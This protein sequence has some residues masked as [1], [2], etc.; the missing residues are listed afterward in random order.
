VDMK[1]VTYRFIFGCCVFAG[2]L[3]A[4]SLTGERRAMATACSS[5]DQVCYCE[6]DS[7]CTAGTIYGCVGVPVREMQCGTASASCVQYVGCQGFTDVSATLCAL[8]APEY[9]CSNHPNIGGSLE[10]YTADCQDCTGCYDKLASFQPCGAGTICWYPNGTNNDAE[11]GTLAGLTSFE[12]VHNG[13][14]NVIS[15]STGTERLNL[16]FNVYKVKKTGGI[17]KRINAKLIPGSMKTPVG[18]VYRLKDPEGKPGDLYWL[19]NDGSVQ[20]RGPVEAKDG[21]VAPLV[22]RFD[23]VAIR[24]ASLEKRRLVKTPGVITSALTSGECSG[25]RIGVAENGLYRVS[26]A[27]L[28]AAG[29]EIEGLSAS[30]LSITN[31]GMPV[32]FSASSTGALAGSDW[33]EFYGQERDSPLSA[34]SVYMLTKDAD[35]HAGLNQSASQPISDG[36]YAP[37]YQSNVRYEQNKLYALTPAIDDY[38]YWAYIYYD[39]PEEEF[40]LKVKSPS[41][42][43]D[44]FTFIADLDGISDNADVEPDHHHQVFFNGHLVKDFKWDGVGLHSLKEE[45]P[46]E[47]LLEGDN[48]VT[49]KTVEDTGSPYD[50]VAVD[51]F[52]LVYRRDFVADDGALAFDYEGVEPNLTVR[53]FPSKDVLAFDVSDPSHP[54]RLTGIDVRE[55]DGAWDVSFSRPDPTVNG[56]FLVLTANKTKAPS[57]IEARFPSDIRSPDNGADLLIIAYDA[58]VPAVQA[59]ADARRAQGLRVKV[60]ST[61]EIFD[62]FGHGAVS[63]QAIK[64]FIAYTT[65]D[66]QAP[67][68]RSVLLVGDSTNDP[69]DYL[70]LGLINYVPS[71]PVQTQLWGGTTSDNWYV[72]VDDS[73][74]YDMAIGR[75]SVTTPKEAEQAVSKVLEYERGDQVSAAGRNRVI[76]IADSDKTNLGQPFNDVLSAM[77]AEIPSGYETVSIRVDDFAT[78]QEA[79]ARVLSELDKGS[80]LVIYVGHGSGLSFGADPVFEAK[81]VQSLPAGVHEPLA[82]ALSCVNGYFT[83]PGLDIMGEALVKPPDR[84][85]I[86][87]W[88]PGDMGFPSRHKLLIGSF[89]RHIFGDKGI[90]AGEA[91]R[92]ALNELAASGG[93]YDESIAQ[94]FVYMGD[95]TMQLHT[96]ESGLQEGSS[97]G[98]GCANQGVETVGLLSFFAVFLGFAAVMV[99]RRRR[100]L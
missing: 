100:A 31:E 28:T 51:G 38:F 92:K 67:A 29:L 72:D 9:R 44:T 71:H 10:Q 41:K 84:G 24:K 66:W 53:G 98:G 64:D 26:V 89:I 45:L 23:P 47:W 57:G 49:V 69:K 85:A 13:G 61:S 90:L 42:G 18:E 87:T 1:N 6:A 43:A 35:F 75:L 14:A 2:I 58:F 74:D 46:A 96:I 4:L 56:S 79:R 20:G 36:A 65:T 33:I 22:K 91:V 93:T 83:Y 37:W 32:P 8:S 12:A 52:S 63:D 70:G 21:V 34:T 97:G 55:T 88:M 27:D 48:T 99:L 19:D 17:I 11:C 80:L 15:W 5:L 94:T 95:P 77:E 50:M 76:L 40:T 68:P 39:H 54:V 82:V 62:E 30:E 59:L 7:E 86:A 78:T 60:V 73:G 16:G 81:D 3:V 25:L